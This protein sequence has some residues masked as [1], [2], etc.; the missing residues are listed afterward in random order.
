MA[1]TV[2]CSNCGKSLDVSSAEEPQQR[3]PC[4]A[5]GSRARTFSV[6]LDLD[7]SATF[8]G[9][10]EVLSVNSAVSLLLQAVVV[11]GRRTSDG[12]L[13]EGV[14]SAMEKESAR[15]VPGHVNSDIDRA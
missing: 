15:G 6:S 7:V 10:A 5:C 1:D 2:T 8:S 12:Q 11:P 3:I 9:S 14:G 4:P 13:I